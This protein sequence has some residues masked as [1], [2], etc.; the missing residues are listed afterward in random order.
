MPDR[1]LPVYCHWY[2][3]E[4]YN[5]YKN[6][7][8][9]LDD[10]NT[11]QVK[12]RLDS[13]DYII[14]KSKLNILVEAIKCGSNCFSSDHAYSV[15]DESELAYTSFYTSVL[16]H[17]LFY[18]DRMKGVCAHKLPSRGSEPDDEEADVGVVPCP[19]L[20]PI[21]LKLTNRGLFEAKF[22]SVLYAAKSVAVQK[23]DNKWPLLLDIPGTCESIGLQVFVANDDVMWII[24]IAEVRPYDKALLCTIYVAVKYLND[25][26]I[27]EVC[28]PT[29]PMPVKNGKYEPIFQY[30]EK[31]NHRALMEDN[32][33]I[34]LFDSEDEEINHPNYEL[35]EQIGF[36]HEI[37]RLSVDGR[38]TMLKRSYIPGSHNPREVTDFK[39]VLECLKR[40]HDYGYVHGD[41]RIYNIIFKRDGT[42][43]L[44]DFDLARKEGETYHYLYNGDCK[45]RHPDARPEQPMKKEHDTFSIKEIIKVFF[46]N[47]KENVDRHQSVDDLV[48]WVNSLC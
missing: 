7:Q 47:V 33:L 9:Q 8:K 2:A 36:K 13:K 31:F 43:H 32:Q 37:M 38:F 22:D 21:D 30:D 15:V 39:G 20:I 24:P 27:V 26:P 42:S 6:A 17:F 19:V 16:D 18:D 14:A 4:L 1:V 46:P 29:C 45:D 10:A 25:Y 48:S 41:V 40:V 28:P 23:H 5:A 3:L 35:L 12:L 44:I 34:K 11:S